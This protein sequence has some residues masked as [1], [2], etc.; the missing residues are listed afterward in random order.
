MVA[1]KDALVG[2]YA[3]ALFEVAEAEGELPAVEDELFAF[4]KALQI[5]TELREALTDPGLPPENKKG[6]IRDLLGARA[7]PH[8]VNILGFLV[9][10]G[11]TRELGRIIEELVE[12]AAERRRHQLAEVRSAVPLDETR[13][14]K[15]AAALSKATG[16]A[17]EVKVIVDPRVIGGI[18]AKVGDEVF[19]GTVRGRLLDARERLAGG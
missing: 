13:R 12:V 11:R 15:L 19:D 9:D 2:G 18:V 14:K 5:R 10:Q 16:R 4:A 8:T 17:I 3:R 7:N 6:V 1:E